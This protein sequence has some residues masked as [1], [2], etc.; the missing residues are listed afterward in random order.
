MELA[1][2]FED[3]AWVVIASLFVFTTAIIGLAL[4]DGYGR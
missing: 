2:S 4:I 3:V 1:M